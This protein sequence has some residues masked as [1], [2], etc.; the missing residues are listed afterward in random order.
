MMMGEAAQR[1]LT[2]PRATEMVGRRYAA[3]PPL[4]RAMRPIQWSKNSL[5]FAAL[6]FD[7]QVFNL[8]SV[9]R[10]LAAALVFCAVSSAIYLINDVRDV[11]QDKLHPRKRYR[12]IAS[13]QVS[14]GQAKRIAVLLFVVGLI[15]AVAIHIEFALVIVGYVT[16]MT[17]YSYGLKRLVI[18]DVFAIAT[19]FVLRAMGGAVALQVAA[20]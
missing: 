12:P 3:L 17:A 14:I 7:R 15:C 8:E 4:I 20:S 11:E 5:V 10:C 9:V 6:L 13:G 2:P 19:G 16:L 18:V 1:D